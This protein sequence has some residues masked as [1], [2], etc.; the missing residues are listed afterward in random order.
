MKMLIA[1]TTHHP[2]PL[3]S[4]IADQALARPRALGALCRSALKAC[5]CLQQAQPAAPQEVFDFVQ[6]GFW[7][8]LTLAFRAWFAVLDGSPSDRDAAARWVES[9]SQ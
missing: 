7:S 1:R 3:V 4:L 2:Y 8:A 9:F 6:M 5:V